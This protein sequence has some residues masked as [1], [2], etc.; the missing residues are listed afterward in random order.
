[1]KKFSFV[2]LFFILGLILPGITSAET[3]VEVNFF[4]NNSCPHCAQEK[5]FL[6]RIE[7]EY[8]QVKVNRY[9]ATDPQNLGIIRRLCNEVEEAEKYCGF[10]PL[11]FV[12]GDFFPGYD[13]EEGIG[14]DIEN[15][16]RGKLGLPLLSREEGI[17]KIPFFGKVN[18]NNYS[19]P[20]QAAILGLFDG[21]NVCSLG[22]LI[23]IL[24]LV[25]ALRSRV[26][27]LVFGG[28]FIVITAVVYGLLI[29]LWYQLFALLSSYM[30]V[31]Q[32]LIGLLGIGGGLYFLRQFLKFRKQG[33]VCE[34]GQ[35]GMTSKFS[36]K[37]QEFMKN[38]RNTLVMIGSI[39]S[40]AVVITILEFPCSAVVPVFFA[41]LLAKAGLSTFSYLLY[42]SIFVLFYML[43]EIIV[44]LI[45]FFTMSLWFASKKFI[46]WIT[47]VEAIMFFSL[48]VYYLMTF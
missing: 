4:Y 16:I 39:I 31:M 35:G 37:M 38:P 11:T 18:V 25:L 27:I 9:L 23:L 48:G 6:D 21:F 36:S 14:R 7:E 32:I 1:M 2:I 28:M 29:F 44:F 22:A 19:L 43:D 26:K 3:D 46:T 20:L 30:Q 15:S 41:G 5:I 33:P 40:F 17:V 24:G 42:I 45:A 12:N 47:L 8:P 34:T 10:V 13:D